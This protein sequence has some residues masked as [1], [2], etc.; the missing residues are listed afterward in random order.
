MKHVILAVLL[1]LVATPC[2]AGFNE[3]K[4]AYDRKDYATAFRECLPLAQQGDAE[5]QYLLSIMYTNGDGVPKNGPEA[6]KWLSRAAEQGNAVAQQTLGIEYRFGRG[7][8]QNDAEAAKWFRRAAEQGDAR[9]QRFLGEMYEEGIGM[10]QDYKWAYVWYD[11]AAASASKERDKNVVEA[12]PEQRA[13]KNRLG[14]IILAGCLEGRDRVAQKLTPDQLASAQRLSRLWQPRP[15][16]LKTPVELLP[17]TAAPPP[18]AQPTPASE[19]EEIPLQ[20]K[21]GV[22]TLPVQINRVLTLH[23]IL[24]TGAAEVNIPTDVALTLLRTGTIKD[25]NDFLPGAAYTLADGTTVKSFRFTIRSLTIGRRRITNVP[26]SIDAIASP[27][28]LGQSFLKRLGTWSMDSHRQMLVLGPPSIRNESLPTKEKAAKAP[29]QLA[30]PTLAHQ[31]DSPLGVVQAY[32][33]DINRYD[34]DA[35]RGK[36]KTPP[37]RL[38]DMVQQTEWFRTEDM[39]LLDVDASTAHVAVV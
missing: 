24:D 35:A 5:A 39:Q 10:P 8:S 12:S 27:L 22:Y 16:R 26:A 6:F 4:A 38:H 18:L 11:R 29:P 25:P 15:E 23:F 2:W 20:S 14:Q 21:G 1:C 30:Q 31:A 37:S 3:G 9:A 36:W 17:G 32:Y 13:A 28:L 7:M 34:V 33:A 19:R